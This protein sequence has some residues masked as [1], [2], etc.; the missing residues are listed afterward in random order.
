MIIPFLFESKTKGNNKVGAIC[1]VNGYKAEFIKVRDETFEI[2]NFT[3]TKDEEQN[4]V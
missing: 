1:L 3:L 2:H 4:N